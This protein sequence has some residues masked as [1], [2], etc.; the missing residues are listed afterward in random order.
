MT[1]EGPRRWALLAMVAAVA[2]TPGCSLLQSP[3][4]VYLLSVPQPG[5]GAQAMEMHL[6]PRE[7]KK[8]RIRGFV[9]KGETVYIITRADKGDL[10]M[11]LADVIVPAGREPDVFRALAEASRYPWHISAADP[12]MDATGALRVKAEF[13]TSYSVRNLASQIKRALHEQ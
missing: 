9:I 12:V 11:A 7:L 4:S 10:R 5:P 6:Q 2:H 13:R 8:E 3:R 1:L